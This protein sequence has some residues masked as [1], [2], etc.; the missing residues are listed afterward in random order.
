MGNE[1]R[2]DVVREIR[3]QGDD[4]VIEVSFVVSVISFT[5]HWIEAEKNMLSEANRS[6]YSHLA[7][8]V[9]HNHWNIDYQEEDIYLYNLF[10]N[11]FIRR[12]KSVFS[13]TSRG[14][15]GAIHMYLAHELS[16]GISKAFCQI[17]SGEKAAHISWSITAFRKVFCAKSSFFILFFDN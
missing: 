11:K 16:S 4:A 15:D 17:Y 13:L 8:G 6:S 7:N 5:H 12:P 3:E 10:I 2:G 9:G 1:G 14:Y